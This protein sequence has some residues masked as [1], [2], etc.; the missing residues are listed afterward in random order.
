MA[1]GGR[2]RLRSTAL[3]CYQLLH[4]AE[5]V[6]ARVSLQ[7]T[8]AVP[9]RARSPAVRIRSRAVAGK[10]SRGLNSISSDTTPQERSGTRLCSALLFN[11]TSL[12]PRCRSSRGYRSLV[13]CWTQSSTTSTT[14]R[15]VASSRTGFSCLTSLLSTLQEQRLGRPA[16]VLRWRTQPE[17][18][19]TSVRQTEKQSPRKKSLTLR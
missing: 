13:T 3:V 9:Q 12:L 16:C 4:A 11:N 2:D 8:P 14:S 18:Q 7:R 6:G 5:S 17:H 15:W 1:I 19:H 10:V